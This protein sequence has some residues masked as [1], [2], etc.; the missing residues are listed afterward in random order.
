[1]I[2]LKTKSYN[3]IL[4]EKLQKISVLS[5]GQIG[6]YEYLTSEEILPFNEKQ[7]IEQ[8]QFTYSSLG[9]AFKEKK[10]NESKL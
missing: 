1:M 6:Q 8:A 10:K 2:R 9:K 5:S 7:I 3:M 4:L